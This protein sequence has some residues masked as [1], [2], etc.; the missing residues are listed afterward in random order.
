MLV[1][2]LPR[3]LQ[4]FSE[5]LANKAERALIR[6]GVEVR[7]NSPVEAIDSEGVVIA[8][9]RLRAKTVIWTA[10]V[11]ASPAGRWLGAEPDRAGRV[12]VGSNLLLPGHPNVFVIGDTA[13][14]SQDGEALPGVAPVAMQEGR[15]VA[16]VI[17]QHVADKKSIPPFRYHSHGNLT[18]VGRSFA[19]AEIRP[20]QL[21]GFLAWVLWLVVHITYLIGFRNRF[22]VLFQWGWE[23]VTR[24]RSARLITSGERAEPL[25]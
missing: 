17:A 18:T 15:Y 12:K 6:L 25:S 21:S 19:V 8:G 2:A 14:L 3:I 20:F 7:T 9:Q 16:R 10:G 13:I 24:Q 11:T 1:E 23:Y 5:S 4:A 22:L